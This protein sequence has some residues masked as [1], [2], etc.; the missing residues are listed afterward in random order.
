MAATFL[1]SNQDGTTERADVIDQF[2]MLTPAGTV[3]FVTHLAENADGACQMKKITHYRSGM[4]IAVVPVVVTVEACIRALEDAFSKHTPAKI[5]QRLNE[6]DTI[7]HEVPTH[8]PKE[9]TMSLEQVIIENTAAV[10]EL[11]KA[12]LQHIANNPGKST[13]TKTVEG[14][15]AVEKPAKAKKEE[16]KAPAVEEKKE[17]PAALSLDTDVKPVAVDLAA[18][19]GRDTLVALLQRLGCFYGKTSELKA[20]QYAEFIELAGKVV[21]GEY[22]PMAG[23]TDD[24]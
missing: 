24:I 2:V 8:Q 10:A 11:T 13:D 7:N 1:I 14:K 20:D 19:K 21:S 5:K 6:P 18:K 23:A 3:L 9:E 16:V 17:E 15:P 22:D 4:A 12:L